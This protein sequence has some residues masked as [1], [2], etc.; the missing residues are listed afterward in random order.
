MAQLADMGIAI[1]QEYRADMAVAGEWQTMSETQIPSRDDELATLSVGV[2]KRKLEGGEEEEGDEHAPEPFVSKA[3]GSRMKVYPG[4][5]EDEEEGLDALL[6]S[7][8]DIKT[9]TKSTMEIEKPA[10]AVAGPEKKEDGGG[11]HADAQVLV[12]AKMADGS[13]IVEQKTEE[14]VKGEEAAPEVVFKKRKPK[15]MRK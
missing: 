11:A 14:E 6:A 4:A 2:R 13:E 3:W 12:Q 7:T 15:A 9:K 8:K 1:P 5:K 10:D